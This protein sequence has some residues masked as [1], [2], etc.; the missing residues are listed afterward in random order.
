MFKKILCPVDL[1]Q[2]SSIALGKAAELAR[3]FGSSLTLLNVH[4]EFMNH[5]EM[6]ML[7][8]SEQ[9]F[10]ELQKRR[11]VASKQKMRE[12]IAEVDAGDLRVEYLLREGKPHREIIQIADEI[13]ADLIVMATDGRSNLGEWVLGSNTERVVH[14]AKCSVLT[15]RI[16]K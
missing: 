10:E 1:S 11:A 16:R 8:V 14:H 4:E 13:Q 7:R 12:M 6:I 2:K 3:L 9:H 15:V 5:H